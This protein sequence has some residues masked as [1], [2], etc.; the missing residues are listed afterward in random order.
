MQGG[1]RGGSRGVQSNK[2][3]G[4]DCGTITGSEFLIG[5]SY[6]QA[7]ILDIGFRSVVHSNILSE[8][9]ATL[10]IILMA[11]P[12]GITEMLQ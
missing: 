4:S 5:Q 11:R 12:I 6:P 8:R 7:D 10:A 2:T 1:Q 9:P 3:I